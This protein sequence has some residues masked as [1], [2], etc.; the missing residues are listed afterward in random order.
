MKQKISQMNP[1]EYKVKLMETQNNQYKIKINNLYKSL[2]EV[3]D[4]LLGAN[5]K[6]P[7]FK[8]WVKPCMDK[9]IYVSSL[10]RDRMM[11]LRDKMEQIK[12]TSFEDRIIQSFYNKNNYYGEINSIQLEDLLKRIYHV[13]TSKIIDKEG[14]DV[15]LL[16][17]KIG[18]SY[19]VFCILHKVDQSF[20]SI[21]IFK[22]YINKINNLYYTKIEVAEDIDRLLLKYDFLT[23]KD[24]FEFK[25]E[26][27]DFLDF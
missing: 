25:R 19:G 10:C 5:T 18:Y 16:L 26:A 1:I 20:D 12:F 2:A 11:Q 17:V 9:S 8:R 24:I 27:Q 15:I 23:K 4:I 6:D 21:D 22:S 3:R 14:N 7:I 13:Y